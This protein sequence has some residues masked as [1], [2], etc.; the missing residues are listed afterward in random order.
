M[1]VLRTRNSASFYWP[2]TLANGINGASWFIYGLAVN[3]PFLSYPNG[4]G[5]LLAAIQMVLIWVFPARPDGAEAMSKAS[6]H[7]SVQDLLRA[8]RTPS[9]SDQASLPPSSSVEDLAAVALGTG[10]QGGE[11]A[12]RAQH[13][14]NQA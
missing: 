3:K 9:T 10:H 2:L 13:G 5:A 7:G 6:V 11:A 8:G 14:A 4:F 12:G 1:Q